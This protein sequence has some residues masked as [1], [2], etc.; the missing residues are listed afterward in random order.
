[1][2]G[3]ATMSYLPSLYCLRSSIRG[4][5]AFSPDRPVLLAALLDAEAHHGLRVDAVH[6]ARLFLRR[7]SF[8]RVAEHQQAFGR[9]ALHDELAVLETL[10]SR[11]AVVPRARAV[12]IRR[13]QQAAAAAVARLHRVGPQAHHHRTVGFAHAAPAG[14]RIFQIYAARFECR[15]ARDE[16][17]CLG[18]LCRHGGMAPL[19]AVGERGGAKRR[20]FVFTELERVRPELLDLLP[21]ELGDAL[22]GPV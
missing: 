5:R 20:D 16:A 21:L 7:M 13:P 11:G 2:A 3:A 1:A 18:A 14:A 10:L 17:F 12:G 22:G 8:E 9:G 4:A 15:A 19:A 6:A